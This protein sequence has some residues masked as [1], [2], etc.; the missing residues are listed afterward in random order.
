M[1]NAFLY[2]VSVGPAAIAKVRKAAKVLAETKKTL[3]IPIL[4]YII[5][6]IH[7]NDIPRSIELFQ[8]R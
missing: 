5:K 4:P 2:L 6:I 1:Q 8:S 3:M 7:L